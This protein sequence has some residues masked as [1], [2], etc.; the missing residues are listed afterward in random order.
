VLAPYDRNRNSDR[1]EEMERE[2]EWEW[3]MLALY[4]NFFI[5]ANQNQV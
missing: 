4:E 2:R 5:N 3:K 1:E